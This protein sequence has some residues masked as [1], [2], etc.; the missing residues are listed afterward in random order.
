[1]SL[2]LAY[3]SYLRD[4]S[5]AA[6]SALIGQLELNGYMLEGSLLHAYTRNPDSW[7]V[8]DVEG[9]AWSGRRAW[10]GPALPDD[11]RAGDIWFDA[12]EIMP[13]ILLPNLEDEEDAIQQSEPDL[14]SW[15]A[16]RPVANWQ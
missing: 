5:D 11:R 4:R 12:L 10:L 8:I 2:S 1:M 7:T 14:L 9:S 6:A 13:M 15:M 3:I 16:L